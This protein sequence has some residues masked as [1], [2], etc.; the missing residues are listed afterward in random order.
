MKIGL[1]KLAECTF[2][3]SALV[4][5]KNIFASKYPSQCRP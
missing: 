2:K 1:L 4:S 3:I 5:N